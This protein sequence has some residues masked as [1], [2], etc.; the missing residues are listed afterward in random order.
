[1]DKESLKFLKTLMNLPSPSGYEQKVRLA[2][3]AEMKK[4]SDEVKSDVHGN[5]IAVVNPEKRPRI[6]LAGHMDELGF[7]VGYIHDKGYIYFNQLGGFDI[8]IIPGRKVRIHTK[9]GD[10]LGVV[11]KKAIHLIDKEEREKVPKPHQLYI[12]IGVKNK[13][14]AQ[15][16]VE[17]GDPMTYD[18]NFERLRKDIYVSRGFDDKTGAFIV[19]EVMKNVFKRRKEFKGSLYSVATVQEEVGMRG[20]RTSAFGIDPDVGIALDVTHATDTPDVDQKKVGEIGLGDGAPITRGPNINHKVFEM[21]VDSAKKHKI[22]YQVEAAARPTGT[23]ANVIQVTR[24]G[25]AT[26]LI[27]IPC[28]YM[29]TYTEVVSLKDV[30]S[31]IDI[32]TEFCLQVDNSVNFIE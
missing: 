1:M 11:G 7:Q 30:E 20:A 22:S 31:A 9:N 32:L 18:T 6:M 3:I 12:D 14:E 13:K 27:S 23:D 4:F 19:A 15:E 25:V 21:L 24:A 26:G 10:I 29:H 17:I 2:W 16:L 5:A 28:R 8:G